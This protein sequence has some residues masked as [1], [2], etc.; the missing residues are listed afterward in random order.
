[1]Y[2]ISTKKRDVIGKFDL[3]GISTKVPFYKF[4]FYEMRVRFDNGQ[5]IVFLFFLYLIKLLN[6]FR[7]KFFG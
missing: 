4:Y 5:N 1:M 3:N 6:K 2:G 7:N